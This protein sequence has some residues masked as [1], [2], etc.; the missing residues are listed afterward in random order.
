[1]LLLSSYIWCCFMCIWFHYVFYLYCC[2][3]YI[4]LSDD[5]CFQFWWCH[6]FTSKVG[7]GI[8]LNSLVKNLVP[9]NQLLDHDEKEIDSVVGRK[10]IK[11]V[12]LWAKIAFVEWSISQ[13]YITRSFVNLL[14]SESFV[15]NMVDILSFFL[16]CKY[17]K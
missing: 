10:V 13:I 6:G 5:T 14:K 4:K 15:N 2:V 12:K 8:K 1:M 3:L 17:K 16:F 7:K 9:N 11:L